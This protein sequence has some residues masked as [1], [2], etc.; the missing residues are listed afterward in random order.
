M[1]GCFGNL[2]QFDEDYECVSVVDWL[3]SFRC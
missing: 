1:S 3:V 2:L